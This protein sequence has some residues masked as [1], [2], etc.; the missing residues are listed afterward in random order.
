MVEKSPKVSE[1]LEEF[2]IAL[3]DQSYFYKKEKSPFNSF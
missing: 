2:R 1:G 3:E